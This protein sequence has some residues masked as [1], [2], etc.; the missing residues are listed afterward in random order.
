MAIQARRNGLLFK[1]EE[2]NPD[3]GAYLYVYENGKCI[4]DT[5]QIG[6]ETC[7]IIAC[8]EYGVG[9]EEWVCAEQ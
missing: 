7:K 1:I 3:V 4:Q 8:R 9:N 6:V 5:L 2:D